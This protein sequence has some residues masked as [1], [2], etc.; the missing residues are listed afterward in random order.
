MPSTATPQYGLNIPARR[1]ANYGLSDWVWDVH[2]DVPHS[3]AVGEPLAQRPDAERLRGVVAGG[4][5]VD[6]GLAGDR[7]DVLARFAGEEGVEPA[8]D[9]VL[10]PVG[11]AP[12]DDADPAHVLRPAVE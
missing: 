12:G 7:H 3:E 1:G 2:P 9:R 6:A 4:D 10:E 11:A 8:V 5:E